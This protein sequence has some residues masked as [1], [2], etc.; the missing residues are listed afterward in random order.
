MLGGFAAMLS[1][2]GWRALVTNPRAALVSALV[3][4]RA[5]G[6]FA[7]NGTRVVLSAASRGAQGIK[8]LVLRAVDALP[9]P[10]LGI[11]GIGGGTIGSLRAARGGFDLALGLGQTATH[12]R[13]LV[14]RFANYVGAKTYWD[15][16]SNNANV[17]DRVASLM[18]QAKSLRF[19]LDGLLEGGRG[20]P[21]TL[22]EVFEFGADGAGVTNWE[23]YQ[24]VTNYM[25]KTTFYAAGKEV[26]LILKNGLPVGWR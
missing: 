15:F 24:A 8:G 14:Q 5:V 23:F 21:Q 7:R 25:S 20:F 11:N 2:G 22:R 12:A 26:Q 1:P 16:F 10:G 9:V 6:A 18:G 13:G 19:N 3:A 4:G 17:Y